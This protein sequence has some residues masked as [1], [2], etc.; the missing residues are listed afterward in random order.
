MAGKDGSAHRWRPGAGLRTSGGRPGR[1]RTAHQWSGTARG[2][3]PRHNHH[4]AGARLL[5]RSDS[6]QSVRVKSAIQ[7]VS[8]VWPPSSENA[9]SHRAVVAVMFDHL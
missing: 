4:C 2:G 3:Q 5:V 8:Q 1:N 7:L 9:C 6:V